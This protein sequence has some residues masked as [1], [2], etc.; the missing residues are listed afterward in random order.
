M[1]ILAIQGSPRK[2]G[3]TATLLMHYL[4]GIEKNHRDA[5][6][7][8]INVAEKNIK[9][10]KGC[11]GCRDSHRKCVINDDMQDLFP[12]IL[13]AD[14]LILATSI[15]WW[16]ITAQAKQFLDR[17]YALNFGDNFKGK[18][19]VL[20]MTYVGEEPN[21]GA[22]IIKNMFNEIC[23]YLEME[24]IQSYGVCTGDKLVQDNPEVQ[25]DVYSLGIAL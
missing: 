19:L 7:K 21:S 9:S 11:Q 23:S 22:E 20:L 2:N 15:Y 16:S 18:K 17:L 25:D 3:N 24:F 4:K 13:E 14:L 6:I 12:I 1:K 8:L 10:C 5:E